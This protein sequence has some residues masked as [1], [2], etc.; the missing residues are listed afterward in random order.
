M[1]KKFYPT[2][3]YESP[4]VI[5]FGALYEKGYRGLLNDID[6]TLVPHGAPSDER[7][8]AFFRMLHGM[9][10]KTC[11]ISNNDEERVAPF[12]LKSESP[13]VFHARKPGSAGYLRGMELMGTDLSDTI[14][15]GD[16]M[17]TDVFGANNIGMK[18]ILVHP[19]KIDTVPYILLKRAGEAIVKVFYSLYSGR[20]PGSL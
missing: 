10:W 4:Y 12:A 18:C 13:Y 1:F 5:D 16:Q 2:V 20:H 15:M 11:V 9:G 17:F 7:S 19:I 3:Y 8:E 14:F 6:N